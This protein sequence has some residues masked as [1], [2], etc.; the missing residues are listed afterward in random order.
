[1]PPLPR[2]QHLGLNPSCLGLCREERLRRAPRPT[3]PLLQHSAMDWHGGQTDPV[4][5]SWGFAAREATRAGILI[6]LFL[7]DVT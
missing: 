2:E 1:M 5:V 7:G 3:E 6:R 4:C